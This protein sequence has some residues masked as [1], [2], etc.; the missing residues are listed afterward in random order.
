V[1]PS[2]AC[3]L[4]SQSVIRTP[5]IKLKILEKSLTETFI[6]AD[7]PMRRQLLDPDLIFFIEVTYMAFTSCFNRYFCPP[8]NSILTLDKLKVTIRSHFAARANG[9]HRLVVLQLI[10]Y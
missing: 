7:Q 9:K 6:I 4:I 2:L 10:A 5:R 8:I 1:G 3:S